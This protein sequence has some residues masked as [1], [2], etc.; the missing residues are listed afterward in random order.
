VML[1]GPPTGE[2]NAIEIGGTKVFW[3]KINKN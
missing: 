3:K 1:E 2:K